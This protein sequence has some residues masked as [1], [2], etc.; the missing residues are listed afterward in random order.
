MTIDQFLKHFPDVQI[1]P[2]VLSACRL[3]ETKG[4]TLCYDYG[5]ETAVRQVMD[6]ASEVPVQ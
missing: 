6:F 5:Y 4:L 2:H 3:L 1:D